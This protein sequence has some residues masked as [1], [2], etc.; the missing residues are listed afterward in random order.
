MPTRAWPTVL[1]TLALAGCGLSPSPAGGGSHPVEV[2]AAENFWGSIVQQVGGD[3]VHVTSVVV[4]PDA[5]PHSYEARPADARAV[6]RARYVVINGAG[7]DS[8]ATKLVDAN[9]VSG[10]SV[11]DVAGLLGKK[12]G[13]NP[14][15]WY[16]PEYVET[17]ID[18]VTADLKAIEPA[19]GDYLDRQNRTYKATGLK[20]YKDIL[21]AIRAKYAGTPVGATESIFQY[22]AASLGLELLTP[23]SYMKAV[24]EGT[25]VSAQD[26]VTVA[27]Q[28]AQ[29][30]VRVLVFNSQN[31]TPEVSA[32]VEAARTQ[33]IPV[34]AVT[35]TL[36]PSTATYQG[37]QVAQLRALLQALGG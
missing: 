24:S 31:Q 22:L 26:K 19:A 33:K 27:A 18:R 9:P 28:V 5:D 20:E 34:A 7:Y 4:N 10:R 32:L 1:L 21:A 16:S 17:V 6:A 29:H 36:T 14:H 12:D 37:W 23:P 11:L 25:E 8:W 15:F 30:R 2:V 3:R 35:E 13:D